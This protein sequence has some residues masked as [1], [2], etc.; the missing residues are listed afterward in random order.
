MTFDHIPRRHV[1]L[2]GHP[3]DAQLP[4]AGRPVL[5]HDVR[6]AGCGSGRVARCPST[7][8]GDAPRRRADADALRA[9]ISLD[10]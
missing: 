10:P 8:H 3:G 2:H 1:A 5:R 4:S 6:W 9:K 7:T